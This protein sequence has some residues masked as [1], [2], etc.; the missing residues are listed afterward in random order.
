MI[1]YF[2]MATAFFGYV[3]PW[4]QMSYWATVVITNLF[5]VLPYVG[6]DFVLWLWGGFGV[7]AP[8]LTRFYSLHF[9][10][11]FILCFLVGLHLF[12]LHIN[13]STKPLGINSGKDKIMFMEWFIKKDFKGFFFVL[14]TFRILKGIFPFLFFDREN[15]VEAKS[16]VTPLHIGPEWYFLAVYAVLRRI[17]KK[18]LGV[19]LLLIFLLRFLFLPF[20]F[21]STN[22]KVYKKIFSIK[23]W[24]FFGCLVLLRILGARNPEKTFI[25]RRQICVIIFFGWF[26]FC[27]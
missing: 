26:F 10:L 2:S 1:F 7:G 22:Q 8:T 6:K 23:F 4:G 27:I 12:F 14:V 21:C 5:S 15:F 17:P 18:S 16:L 11:P 19:I 3:L 13:L 24:I 20:F 25:L 9:L